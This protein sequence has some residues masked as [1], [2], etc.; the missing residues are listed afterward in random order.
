MNRSG[1]VDPEFFEKLWRATYR[2]AR[3][4]VEGVLVAEGAA[5]SLTTEIFENLLDRYK[6]RPPDA[7][8]SAEA[9]EGGP[10]SRTKPLQLIRRL[11]T[12]SRAAGGLRSVA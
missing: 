4:P 10:S 12:S 7:E 6:S 5:A 1:E 2:R 3:R 8:F 11:C 9:M